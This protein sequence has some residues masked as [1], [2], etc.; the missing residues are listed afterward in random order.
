MER[1]TRPV[2]RPARTDVTADK[3]NYLRS[4]AG[5]NWSQTARILGVSRS[6]LYQRKADMQLDAPSHVDDNRLKD[7]ISDMLQNNPDLGEAYVWG[8]LKGKGVIVTRKRV[9]EALRRLR[10][11]RGIAPAIQRR[12]YSVPGPNYLW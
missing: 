5:F 8:A 3:I 10:G 12:V 4:Q 6:T 1:L 2:G 9:R 11:P 7:E